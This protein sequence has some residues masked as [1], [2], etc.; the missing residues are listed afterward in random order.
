MSLRLSPDATVSVVSGFQDRERPQ[1][2]W[3]RFAR[4]ILLAAAPVIV[5]ACAQGTPMTVEGVT[6]LRYGSLTGSPQ[7]V[8]AGTIEFAGGCVV[9]DHG[10]EFG[11]RVVIWPSGARLDNSGGVLKVIVGDVSLT[12]GDRV[13][14]AGGGYDGV[15][16][17]EGLVGAIPPACIAERY[18]LATDIDAGPG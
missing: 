18:W 7:A 5:A 6:I 1:A 15:A 13:S 14:L 2:A 8:T 4:S 11:T 12:P 3:M 17:V 16:S 10:D 9:L